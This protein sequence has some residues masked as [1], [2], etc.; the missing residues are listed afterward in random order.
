MRI[1]EEEEEEKVNENITLREDRRVRE[2]ENKVL[3]R[4][5]GPKRIAN[6]EWRRLHNV[7]LLNLYRWPNIMRVFKSRRLRWAAHVGR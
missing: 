4:I 1:F 6:G 5:F 7:E 2:F 3:R